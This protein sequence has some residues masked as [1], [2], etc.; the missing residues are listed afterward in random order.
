M[1]SVSWNKT[2]NRLKSN[3]TNSPAHSTVGGRGEQRDT[4]A[5]TLLGEC[6]C[7]LSIPETS[8]LERSTEHFTTVRSSPSRSFQFIDLHGVECISLGSITSE[9]TPMKRVT[10]SIRRLI[11]SN[12]APVSIGYIS[13]STAI[14]SKNAIDAI[15][16]KWDTSIPLDIYSQNNGVDLSQSLPADY[17][18]IID[19]LKNKQFDV[20]LQKLQV[21]LLR[22]SSKGHDYYYDDSDSDDSI[23]LCGITF[24]NIAVVSMLVGRYQESIELFQSAVKAKK[25][26]FGDD[27][28]LVAE[29]LNEL[30]IL[31]FAQERF[32]EAIA[33]FRE[34]KEIRMKQL[35]PDHPKVAMAMNNIACITF[36]LGQPDSA[37]PIFKEGKDILRRAMGSSTKLIKLDLLRAATVSCNVGYIESRL[38]NYDEAR[39]IFE[40][41]LLVQ[42]SVLDDSYETLEDTLSNINFTNAFHS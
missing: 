20:A 9:L 22:Q 16:V 14:H 41:A 24:H 38:K 11:A 6:L 33:V 26:S 32:N 13:G 18:C 39:D 40:E 37:L 25:N 12:E 19:S 31:Y 15:S 7:A 28:H 1:F 3:V 30:G 4:I 17:I 2:R 5:S 21:I 35:G 36:L 10:E 8:E 42:Q 23:F 34:T 27:H 29:S